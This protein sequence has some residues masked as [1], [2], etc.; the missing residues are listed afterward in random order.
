MILWYKSTCAKKVS[1]IACI[2][3]LMQQFRA[4]VSFCPACQRLMLSIVASPKDQT[5]LYKVVVTWSNGS[6][7]HALDT[8]RI[9]AR[10]ILA[11][12]SELRHGNNNS[13]IVIT[14]GIAPCDAN[15]TILYFLVYITIND[16]L[17]YSDWFKFSVKFQE[18]HF[19]TISVTINMYINTQCSRLFGYFGSLETKPLDVS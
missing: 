8:S 3:T 16:E 17:L 15:I 18:P 12:G 19:I 5:W 10:L 2:E 13:L 14:A 4:A 11:D 7:N 9:S 1:L 6:V